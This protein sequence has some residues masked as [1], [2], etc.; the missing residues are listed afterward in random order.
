[1]AYA[2]EDSGGE[3]CVGLIWVAAAEAADLLLDLAEQGLV[4]GGAFCGLGGVGMRVGTA[5]RMRVERVEESNRIERLF[6]HRDRPGTQNG[7]MFCTIIRGGESDHA[8]LR[9]GL[10]DLAS[11]G[12]AIQHRHVEVHQHRIRT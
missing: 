2:V 11:R 10:D 8:S 9:I 7:G 4:F 3:M 5:T 6:Q 12:N 1:M